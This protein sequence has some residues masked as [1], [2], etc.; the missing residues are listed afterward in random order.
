MVGLAAP[1]AVK[2]LTGV[3]TANTQMVQAWPGVDRTDQA[4]LLASPRTSGQAASTSASSVSTLQAALSPFRSLTD[5]SVS[6]LQS[7]AQALA[8][9]VLADQTDIAALQAKIQGSTRAIWK[10]R[11][12]RYSSSGPVSCP[13]ATST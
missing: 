8:D 6:D 11:T 13:K 10:R 3:V 12:P 4:A 9:R 5:Q 1:L 2:A 7:D